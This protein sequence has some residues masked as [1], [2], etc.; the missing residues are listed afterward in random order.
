[1]TILH[2]TWSIVFLSMALT[3]SF[4]RGGPVFSLVGHYLPV[5]RLHPNFSI[6]DAIARDPRA[7]YLISTACSRKHLPCL[8]RIYP[9]KPDELSSPSSPGISA[10]SCLIVNLY[11]RHA[12]LDFVNQL[13]ACP[14]HNRRYLTYIASCNSITCIVLNPDEISMI[15]G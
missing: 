4:F 8:W 15:P 9:C 3:I 2:L 10:A 14:P 1:M 7:S 12:Q 5:T 6:S 13:D 11:Y